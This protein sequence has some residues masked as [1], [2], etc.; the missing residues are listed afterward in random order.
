MRA[1]TRLGVWLLPLLCPAALGQPAVGRDETV[2]PD[3]PEGWA[4]R[5][6]AATALF[7]SFGEVPELAPW[8]WNAAVDVGHIPPLDDTQRR[9]GLGGAKDEDLNRSPLFGRLRVTFGLP[10]GFVA[11]AAWTPPVEIDGARP[12]SVVA[13]AVGRRVVGG[14]EATLSVRGIVQAGKVTGDITCPARLAGV[15]D[16]ESNPFGCRAPSHDTFTARYLGADATFG[17]GADDWRGYLS[18][19][20]ARAWLEVQVDAELA[21]SHERPHLTSTGSPRWFTVGAQRRLD[22]QW[23]IAV[24]VLHAPLNVRRPPDFV[25][26]ADPLVGLRVQLRYAP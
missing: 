20:I 17:W 4:M 5:Y 11:K 9:V 10:A 1:A 15:R 13:A 16:A 8:R 26:D 19:G 18:A 21:A 2:A 23:S 6:F 25:R 3:S 24:E 14:D 12:R 7:T 22:P